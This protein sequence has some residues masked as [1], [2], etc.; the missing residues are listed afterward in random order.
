MGKV[1]EV[2]LDRTYNL[3]NYES[4][5]IGLTAEVD[6]GETPEDVFEDLLAEI[7]AFKR[8]IKV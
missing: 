3:G 2:R 6:D 1:T 4:A 7:K 8:Q 5:K